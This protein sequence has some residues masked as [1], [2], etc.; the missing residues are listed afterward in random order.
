MFLKSLLIFTALIAGI[1]EHLS[2]FTMISSISQTA[3]YLIWLKA[4]LPP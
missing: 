2:L 3:N 1:F 4:N